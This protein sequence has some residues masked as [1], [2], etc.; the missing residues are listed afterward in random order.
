M[1][2]VIK[3]PVNW[4]QIKYA[5]SIGSILIRIARATEGEI[6]LWK[7]RQALYHKIGWDKE[8]FAHIISEL[9]GVI[10]EKETAGKAGRPGKIL[11]LPASWWEENGE[12]INQESESMG[13]TQEDCEKEEGKDK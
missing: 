5:I 10:T 6:P 4:P 2:K 7:A 3:D 1:H 13:D 11:I 9:N 12:K 8:K